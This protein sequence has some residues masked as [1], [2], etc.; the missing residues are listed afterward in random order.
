[1]PSAV[2]SPPKRLSFSTDKPKV[3][4]VDFVD[5]EDHEDVWYSDDDYARIRT[6]NAKT[7]KCLKNAL[8]IN[9][10]LDPMSL[11]FCVRSTAI[12]TLNAW[13]QCI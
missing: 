4:L 12:P 5:F 9:P 1:M 11:P 2:S 6:E 13:V 10:D 8:Q 3:H 7:A